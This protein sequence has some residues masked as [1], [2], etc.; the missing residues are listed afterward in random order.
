M[1][2]DRD[3]AVALAS[4]N[5]RRDRAARPGDEKSRN[6]PTPSGRNYGRDQIRRPVTRLGEFFL[7]GNRRGKREGYAR[8][9][10]AGEGRLLFRGTTVDI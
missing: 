1:E 6:R 4:F 7:T 8:K 10:P 3:S 5:Q 9:L 2:S